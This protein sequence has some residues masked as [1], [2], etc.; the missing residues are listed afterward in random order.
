MY[1]A[2]KCTRK[3]RSSNGGSRRAGR[4]CRLA[5][6]ALLVLTGTPIAGCDELLYYG[7]FAGLGYYGYPDWIYGPN[8]ASGVIQSVNDYRQDVFFTASDAWD[9][10]IRGE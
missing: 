2:K 10:Y 5:I 8:D 3:S 4:A 6:V 7:D 1:A 9:S